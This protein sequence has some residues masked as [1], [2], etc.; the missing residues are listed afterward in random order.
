MSSIRII[1]SSARDLTK[2]G[3][4]GK[5]LDV[6]GHKVTITKVE[7]LREEDQLPVNPVEGLDISV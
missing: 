7:K 6:D 5:T 1:V 4:D 2:A 3:L